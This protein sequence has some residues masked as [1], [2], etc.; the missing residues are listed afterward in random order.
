MPSRQPADSPA[1]SR[2]M[3]LLSLLPDPA[4]PTSRPGA[5][6][7]WA[8]E[9]RLGAQLTAPGQPLWVS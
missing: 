3:V 7:N 9:H 4:E 5:V 6:L 2:T 8:P 1:L